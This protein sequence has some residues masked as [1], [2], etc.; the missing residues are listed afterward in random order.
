MWPCVLFHSQHWDVIWGQ[1][2]ANPVHT[3]SLCEF[4]HASVRLNINVLVSLVSSISSGSYTPLQSFLS[5]N[6]RDLIVISHLEL[7]VQRSLTLFQLSTC[8][9]LHLFQSA[10]EGSLSGDG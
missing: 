1:T 10:A 7:S 9:C 8:R 4:M 3:A 6:K 5:S 2:S